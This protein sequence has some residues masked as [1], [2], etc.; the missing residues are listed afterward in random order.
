MAKLKKHENKP[1]TKLSFYK[2]IS[3][4]ALVSAA[5]GMA[6]CESCSKTPNEPDE[7]IININ[8]PKTVQAT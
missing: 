7:I 6:I 2:F 4:V 5:V 1:T 3:L 8:N